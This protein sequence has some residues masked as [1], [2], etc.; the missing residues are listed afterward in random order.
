MGLQ[1]GR[2]GG[3][4]HGGEHAG[5]RNDA[6]AFR[7]DPA[8]RAKIVSGRGSEKKVEAVLSV[9]DGLQDPAV[10]VGEVCPRLHG[11]RVLE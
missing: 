10:G 7:G 9:L 8:R 5:R 3:A 11:L 6:A 1:N 4:R 2:Q